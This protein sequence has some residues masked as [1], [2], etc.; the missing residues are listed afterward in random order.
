MKF[1]YPEILYALVAIAIPII[2]HL[3]NFRKFKKVAFSNVDFLKEIKQETQSKSKLKHLLILISRILAIACI[4]FAFAQPFIPLK[5]N[6]LA[7]TGHVVSVFLDNSF[8]MQGN[9]SEGPMLEVARNKALE[10]VDYYDQTDKFQLI[11]Q[12]FEGRHQRLVNKDEMLDLIG[13]VAI[14]PQSHMLSDVIS[15]QKDAILQAEGEKLVYVISDFQSSTADFSSCE[16][17]SS[18]QVILLPSIRED[19]SNIYLDSL[20]FDTPVR[21]LNQAEKLWYRAANSGDELAE[22]VP[23]ELRIAGIQKAVGA[24]TVGE[25]DADSS[26][27]FTNIEAGW[28]AAWVEIADYP[29][30]FDDRFYFSFEVKDQIIVREIKGNEVV[31]DYVENIFNDDAFYDFQSRSEADFTYE[32]LSSTDL[33]VLNQLTTISSGLASELEKFVGSGGCVFI[34]PS[35]KSDISSY[36][37]LLA[38]ISTDRFAEKKQL[39]TRVSTLN[40]EHFLYKGVF[41]KLPKNLDLP[42]VSAYYPLQ[43]SSRT[44]SE[45]ILGLKTGESFLT[46]Y[47]F[48]NGR[49]YLLSSSLSPEDGNLPQHAIFVTTALRIAEFAQ[50]NARNFFTIGKD[51]SVELRNVIVKADEVFRLKKADSEAEFIPEH[52]NIGGSTRIYLENAIQEA[53]HYW[54]SLGND[55]LALLSFNYPREESILDS[56]SSA[57]INDELGKF[58][59]NY[60]VVDNSIESMGKAIGDLTQGRQLWRSLIIWALIFLAIEILLIKF[61]KRT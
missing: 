28:Q 30:T 60:K 37:N 2:V 23:A 18:F 3:F 26:L 43:S 41:E 10:I 27:S 52:R 7:S 42:S 5:E 57:E 29:V 33:I 45:S 50:P 16:V 17:D 25:A 49:M 53:G 32:E 61:W 58:G 40:T 34:I 31:R 11:T 9:S 47:E 21:Q 20:W 51:E 4:V 56:K 44:S 22:N 14:S 46:A 35:T 19:K 59:L 6:S 12:D 8:S 24:T 48:G 13:D 55:S 1:L 39:A 15:R 38:K 54:L 36:N